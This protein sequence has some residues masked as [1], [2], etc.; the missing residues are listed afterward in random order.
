MSKSILGQ[1]YTT[2]YDYILKNIKIPSNIKY[3]IEPFAGNGD[4][5]NFIVNKNIYNIECYDIDPKKNFIKKRDTLKNPPNYNNKFILTN[6][7]YLARNKSKNKEIYDIYS[8]NDLYKC[9]IENIINTNC[10]GGI[11]IIPLNFLSSIR[12]ND[13]N[14]RKRFFEKYFISVLNIFEEQVFN[15]TKYNVISFLFEKIGENKITKCFLYPSKKQFNF[16]FYSNK[17]YIIGGE[18]YDL[19]FSS[20]K[21]KITRATKK[22]VENGCIN[23]NILLK[24]IDNNSKNKIN[25]KIV[26]NNEIYIDNTQKLTARSY[27]TLIIEPFIDLNKQKKL[28][29]EFNKF[30]NLYREKY[31]SMFLT[32]YRESSDIA[33]KRISFNF[34]FNICRYILYAIDNNINI[35]NLHP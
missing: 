13:I 32:N 25:L 14:L 20:S 34:A 4:L 18:L 8:Q 6:P 16:S 12:K 26:N 3:I 27:A 5:L 9:F 30:I 17:N 7:P 15:D 24:C 11:L 29:E 22:T 31:N 19:N 35:Y 23:S 33:R 10:K 21:Y 1:F 28:V 2:N